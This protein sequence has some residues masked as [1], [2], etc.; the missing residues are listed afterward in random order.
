MI[1]DT[2]ITIRTDSAVKHEAAEIF[3]ALGIDACTAMNNVSASGDNTSRT[4]FQ[5]CS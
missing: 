1:Y 4:A 2:D 3:D 5:G